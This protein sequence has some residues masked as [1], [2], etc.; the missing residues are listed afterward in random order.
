MLWGSQHSLL[1]CCAVC[2]LQTRSSASLARVSRA[3]LL[4]AWQARQRQHTA[5]QAGQHGAAQRPARRSGAGQC[6][7][8]HAAGR[9][10]CS[11]ARTQAVGAAHAQLC[12][13]GVCG[14]GEGGSQ[15]SKDST[16]L[17]G[18]GWEGDKCGRHQCIDW[19]GWCTGAAWGRQPGQWGSASTP[20]TFSCAVARGRGGA[21]VGRAGNVVVAVSERV[22]TR[23]C[24]PVGWARRQAVRALTGGVRLG[25]QSSPCC[26]CVLL[27]ALFATGTFGRV[28]ECWDRKVKDY[29][30]V[31]I[32]RNVDKYRHAA[33]IEVRGQFVCL[34]GPEGC[35]V[36]CGARAV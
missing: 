15:A 4:R 28:L 36:C 14:G 7:R 25:Q 3:A 31:K 33:M 8:A 2:C 22:V 29:V 32:V 9:Q 27:R 16:A 35:G 10:P 5:K 11:M 26:T 17:G 34:R 23:C 18:Q 19:L 24:A 1:P 6:A 21:H 30:A 20:G 13:R 12:P